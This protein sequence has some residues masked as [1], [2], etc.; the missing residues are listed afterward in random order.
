LQA[1]L[2]AVREEKPRYFLLA[3]FWAGVQMLLRSEF[4]ALGMSLIL[5]AGILLT[6][7]MGYK[8]H[9][10]VSTVLGCVVACAIITPWMMR[11]YRVFGSFVP[12]VSR[13]WHEVW[14]GNNLYATGA[15]WK[16]DGSRRC[17][18]LADPLYDNLTH[19]FDNILYTNAFELRANDIMKREALTFIRE[20]PGEAM[21]LAG[22]KIV[23]LWVHDLYNPQSQ[24]LPYIVSMIGVSLLIWCGFGT[25]LQRWRKYIFTASF[26]M[27]AVYILFYTG[28]F[29]LTFVL[30]RYRIYVFSGLLP[31]TGLGAMAL[32]QLFVLWVSRQKTVKFQE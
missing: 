26:W 2:L 4:L 21:V 16:E 19:E 23:F 12:I 7:K 8:R 10:L 25:L 9:I 14:R 6:W 28:I 24:N 29:A 3:G 11:N 1:L 20:H 17:S 32:W 13:S 18:V 30:P 15:E 31:L 27:Y 5:G 22:K